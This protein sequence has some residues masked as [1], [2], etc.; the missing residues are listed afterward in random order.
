M[1]IVIDAV[2][3]N[4]K[5]WAGISNYIFNLLK[6]LAEFDEKNEY[7]V[8]CLR[9][10][11]KELGI[12]NDNLKCKEIPDLFEDSPYWRSW[13]SWYYTGISVQLL[14][15]RPAVFL[16]TYLALP[17]YCP[18]PKI[19]VVHDLIPL[20]FRQSYSAR[21]RFFFKILLSDA[22]KRADRIV[23][24]SNSTKSDLTKHL[25]ADPDKI[26][27]VYEGYDDHAFKPAND[28]D[29]IKNMKRKYK[30]TG[31][32]IF[33]I[34]TLEPRKNIT[35]LIEAYA[36]LIKDG[37]VNHKLVITGEKGVLYDD[38]FKKVDKLGL[39]REVVFTGRAPQEDLPLLLNGADVFVYPS[40]YEGFGLP[41]LEAMACGTPVITSNVSSLPEVVGDA[42]IL[43]DPFNVDE[44]A[45]ALYQV[46]SNN[47]LQQKMRQKGLERAKMF[48]WKN[49]TNVMVKLFEDVNSLHKIK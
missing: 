49:V 10:R 11:L 20:I 48:L 3:L 36:N 38:I 33:N 21:Y 37:N 17:W 27:V 34:G 30:I 43:V 46:V 41:P 44:I 23:S 45:K 8:Y 9:Y 12:E 40:L 24:V 25:K 5:P 32:Y 28:P 26:S 29:Q 18:C 6:S 4:E 22:V 47:E 1:H 35:T 42:G 16:S 7:T 2:P 14:M 31:N 13:L 39:G 15:D 19:I